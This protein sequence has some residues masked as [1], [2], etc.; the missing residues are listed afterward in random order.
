[1]PTAAFN[2]PGY[3]LTLALPR[4]ISLGI[5]KN[6]P[7]P[8]QD[9]K[10]FIG[11]L[12][13]HFR[14]CVVWLSQ[15]C[16]HSSTGYKVQ[17]PTSDVLCSVEGT[18]ASESNRLTWVLALPLSIWQIGFLNPFLSPQ[19]TWLNSCYTF[20]WLLF[21]HLFESFSTSSQNHSLKVKG[22]RGTNW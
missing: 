1:M 16:T 8:V 18:Q 12:T 4:S 22:L 13:L 20:L 21:S 14:T 2:A 11:S 15:C 19:K 17:R 3:L 6:S 9:I 10:R 7:V 5:M